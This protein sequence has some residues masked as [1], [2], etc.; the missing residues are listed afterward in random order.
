MEKKKSI[1][2]DSASRVAGKERYCNSFLYSSIAMETD[3]TLV[4]FEKAGD[5]IK[6]KSKGECN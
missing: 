1:A 3:Y 2:R 5:K 4:G 6:V